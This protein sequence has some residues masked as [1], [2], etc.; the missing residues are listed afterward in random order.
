M[1]LS[2]FLCTAGTNSAIIH[3]TAAEFTGDEIMQLCEGRLAAGLMPDDAGAVC[4][5]TRAIGE[6]QW[7]LALSGE[8]FDGHDFLGDAFSAGAIGAIVE[9]RPNYPIGNQQFP[10]IAV[11]DTLVA[12][13]RLAT[14]WRKRIRPYVIGVTGSSGKTTTKEMIAA[15]LQTDFRV[16]KSSANE[17]NEFGVPKTIL[18]MPDDTQA[19]VVEMAMR[20]AGQIDL[21][22][23]C[24]QP[25]AGV[26]TNAGVAH[27]EL[28]GS[29]ENIAAAKSELLKH[30]NKERGVAIIGQP[31]ERLLTAA[32]RVFPGRTLTLNESDIEIVE[33][34]DSATRFKVAGHDTVFEVKAHGYPLIADAWCAITAGLQMKMT[35]KAI[36]KGLGEFAPVSGRG[37]KL[38]ADNGAL[39]VDE[40]YNANP[41]S[42]KASVLGFLDERAFP[43]PRKLLVLGELA[44]LGPTGHELH[45]E[46][47]VWLKDRSTVAQS[48]EALITVGSTAR[49]IADGAEGAKFEVIAASDQ[50]EAEKIL[51][52]RLTADACVLIKGSHCAN[53]DRMVSR[54]VSQSEPAV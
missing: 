2:S 20:G 1:K 43:Y 6:G 5:D 21:L 31:V 22:A 32:R 28:L 40:T 39:V 13:H 49:H 29:L 52:P 48:L 3:M 54:L 23:A 51:R 46:L 34:T 16:W 25:D 19:L 53:L 47:G 8:R 9:E 4:T 45:R 26:I 36:A 50:A 27:L 42:V 17:N 44:E 41:E 7:Y 35:E 38:I 15:V 33:T 11:E 30:L 12:Y 37:N 18:A 10:L 24:A 14:N